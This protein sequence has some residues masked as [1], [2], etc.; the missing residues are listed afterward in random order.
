MAIAET[1]RVAYEGIKKKL[2]PKQQK[3]YDALYILGEATNERL[4]DVLDW[5]INEITPRI[6]ELVKYGRVVNTRLGNNRSGR[7]A[8]L[9]AITDPND[10]KLKEMANDC[11]G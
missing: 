3:V 9:W 10:L 6:N 11:E 8:K 7:K 5:P 2:G 4:S 1:S